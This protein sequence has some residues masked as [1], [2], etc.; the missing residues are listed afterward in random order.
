MLNDK[1]KKFVNDLY[2]MYDEYQYYRLM[3]N[4]MYFTTMK[5]TR[6]DAYFSYI[7]TDE[8]IRHRLYVLKQTEILMS[9]IPNIFETLYDNDTINKYKLHEIQQKL[10]NISIDADEWYTFI[11]E[12]NHWSALRDENVMKMYQKYYNK[13]DIYFKIIEDIILKYN[14]MNINT[15]NRGKAYFTSLEGYD[16]SIDDLYFSFN[17]MAI[18]YV[19][20]LMVVMQAQYQEYYNVVKTYLILQPINDIKK[21]IDY[22][23]IK[24]PYTYL[25]SL[26]D[27]SNKPANIHICNKMLSENEK[28]LTT[29]YES[30]KIDMSEDQRK[31]F[32]EYQSQ[33]IDNIQELTQKIRQTIEALQ[34]NSPDNY[35]DTQAKNLSM[36]GLLG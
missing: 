25:D 8:K 20:M 24:A 5:V 9:D 36:Q 16:D 28:L 21:Y 15:I 18:S 22:F 14:K 35:F 33:V 6:R 19:K 26:Y 13:Q 32:L 23:V 2:R 12:T 11:D 10:F 31:I 4:I 3:F 17:K 27:M 30:S 1:D 7:D 34:S 29:A